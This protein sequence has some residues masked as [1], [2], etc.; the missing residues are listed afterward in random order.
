MDSLLSELV[1]TT[2]R[3]RQ[4]KRDKTDELRTLSETREQLREPSTQNK[5][6]IKANS[7]LK[8][9]L[10]SRHIDIQIRQNNV[11]R[12]SQMRQATDNNAN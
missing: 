9:T 2:L 8:S 7:K 6:Y 10:T 4:R 5:L 12:E 3:K 11:G 1:A